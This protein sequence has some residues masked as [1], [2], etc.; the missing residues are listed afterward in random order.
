LAFAN[1][2][3]IDAEKDVDEEY[4]IKYRQVANQVN[5]GPYIV[6][7]EGNKCGG[8]HLKVS[9]DVLSTVRVGDV[10]TQCDSCSRI[11]YSAS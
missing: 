5:R 7:L 11:V 6:A 9:N 8:C 10:I 4:L 2:A 3:V 1:T